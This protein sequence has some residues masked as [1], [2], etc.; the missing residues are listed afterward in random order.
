MI[1]IIINRS[2]RELKLTILIPIFG[3]Y[4]HFIGLETEKSLQIEYIFNIIDVAYLA[5]LRRAPPRGRQD[6]GS[7]VTVQPE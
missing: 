1:Y 6:R 7:V 4:L 5:T 3:S 2:K